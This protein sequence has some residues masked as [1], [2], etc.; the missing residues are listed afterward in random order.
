MKIACPF[1]GGIARRGHVCGAVSGALMVIGL[2][3]GKGVD[4][5]E[6]CKQH[7]YD[8]VIKYIDEFNQQHGSIMCRTLIG[9]DLSN[10]VVYERAKLDNLFA[11]ICEN[12]I[13]HA[14]EILEKM[15][16]L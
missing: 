9:R 3:H 4:D 15:L 11:L 5:D 7:S 12:Y 6:D 13:V 16:V 14:V 2:C 8:L 10:P 1:G